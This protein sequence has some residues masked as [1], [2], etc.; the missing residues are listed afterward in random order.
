MKTLH[1]FNHYLPQTENWLHT[2]I[3]HLPVAENHIAAQHYLKHNF[4]DPE[5]NFAESYLDGVVAFNNGLEKNRFIN[6]L[7]KAVIHTLPLMLGSDEGRL[8]RYAKNH[9]I[10]IAHAHFAPMGWHY[11]RVAEALSLPYVISFYGYDYEMLPHV[12]PTFQK[13]Y[14]RLFQFADAFICEGPHGVSILEERGCPPEKIHIIPL[15][16]EVEKIPVFHRT[17]RS[18]ELKLVQVA[19][20]AEKKGQIYSVMA[21]AE[22]LKEC[23]NMKLVL[24]GNEREPLVKKQ[25]LDFIEEKRLTQKVKVMG[26]LDYGQLHQFLSGFHV[27][28]HPSCYAQNMDCEGGAPVILLEAQAT[29]MPVIGTTH[30]DI[31]FVVKD[32]VTGR[33][34]SEKAINPLTEAI[35]S[36]YFQGMEEY[37]AWGARCRQQIENGFDIRQTSRRLWACYEG[38]LEKSGDIKK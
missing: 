16:V 21:F 26:W 29:G 4:Y 10:D 17:K 25:V 7:R 18:K 19:S 6:L 9:Q 23:P 15:G 33:L 12:E 13:R 32:N 37:S 5:F 38:L 27:F 14:C 24:V 20:F 22:A 8:I 1:L 2:L 31:P 30:C 28:I 3:K 35:K 34:T 11:R 36:F